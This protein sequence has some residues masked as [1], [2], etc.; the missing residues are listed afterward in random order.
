MNDKGGLAW[1]TVWKET[2]QNSLR[3]LHAHAEGAQSSRL[4]AVVQ[5]AVA[6]SGS[7]ASSTS[8]A[9][10]EESPLEQLVSL[11]GQRYH[12]VRHQV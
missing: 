12:M 9:G 5:D 1:R 3:S 2:S 6:E 4:S 8:S 7:M 11:L 10:Q